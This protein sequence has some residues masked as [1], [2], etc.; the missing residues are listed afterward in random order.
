MNLFALLAQIPAEA[1]EG[2]GRVLTA[3]LAGDAAKAE[4]EVRVTAE[5]VAAKLA[6]DKAFEAGKAA[7]EKAR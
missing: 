4:R 1:Y 5:T 2:L 3:M 6:I 7:R